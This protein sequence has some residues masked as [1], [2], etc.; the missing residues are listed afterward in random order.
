MF[1]RRVGVVAVGF[2]FVALGV[3]AAFAGIGF[4]TD[5][6]HGDVEGA[7]RLWRQCAQRHAWRDKTFADFS[8]RL[9][10]FLRN[11]RAPTRTEVHQMAQAGGRCVTDGF[12]IAAEELV[13]FLAYGR[14]QEVDGFGGM[15]MS[16]S[17]FAITIESTD[18][19]RDG[20][21]G[22]GLGVLTADALLNA[23]KADARNT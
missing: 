14:L 19:Q 10:F 15:G 2:G 20:I 7:V 9:D 1:N 16:L 17:A 18:R 3:F 11:R 12:R 4:C 13:A 22:K 6:I 21:T 5:A 23:A 8:D